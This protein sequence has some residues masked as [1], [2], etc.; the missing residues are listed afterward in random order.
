[1]L[2]FNNVANYLIEYFKFMQANPEG[3]NGSDLKR[4]FRE[5]HPEIDSESFKNIF[6]AVSHERS[7][8]RHVGWV[9]LDEEH[10][11]RWF[12]TEEGEKAMQQYPNPADF[13]RAA[14]RLRKLSERQQATEDTV[15]NTENVVISE[16][17]ATP[18]QRAAATF[19]EA[20]ETAQ[21]S[22]ASYLLSLNEYTFQDV[23]AD[24]L[25][26][27]GYHVDWVAPPGPDGGCD[28]VAFSDALGVSNP[29]VKV[30]VKRKKDKVGAPEVKS[31]A[32]NI[33]DNE[34]GLFVCLGG[35]TFEAEKYARESCDRHLTLLAMDR[36]VQLWIENYG[37]LTDK[38]K[39]RFRLEPI[40]YV[41]PD[42]E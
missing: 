5:G 15:A 29:I 8:C 16:E 25:T 37:K 7:H 18:T 28:I 2:Q 14:R 26:A 20:Q 1:M 19:D 9:H 12:V 17:E 38:A 41:R 36:F 11:W 24:L 35:F 6:I 42:T 39:S 3:I 32:A 34:S 40:Y 27:L 33:L 22:I 30:Q 31:F 13:C 23:V 10:G 21:E 4:L